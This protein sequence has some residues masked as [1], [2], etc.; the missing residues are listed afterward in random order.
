MYINLFSKLF[1]LVFFQCISAC[2]GESS[3]NKKE[4]DDAH[5]EVTKSLTVQGYIEA[6]NYSGVEVIFRVENEVF[7]AE[8]D[9]YGN[10][11]VELEVHELEVD[12]FVQAEANFPT[13]SG[14]KLVS[15]LGSFQ[16]LLEKSG[17][18]GILVR[19]ELLNVNITS[20]STALSAL[21]EVE[22]N[23][24]LMSDSQYEAA[25]QQVNP[26][27]VFDIA[28]YI[29]LLINNP[30]EARFGVPDEF[31]DVYELATNFSLMALYISQ[32]KENFLEEFESTKTSISKNQNLV[33]ASPSILSDIEDTYYLVGDN[34]RLTL[35]ADGT[36]EVI[37]AMDSAVITWSQS[38]EGLI[39]EGAD[40]VT[41]YYYNEYDLAF[42]ETHIRITKLNWVSNTASVDSVILNSVQYEHYPGGE[43]QGSQFIEQTL[44]S[45]AVRSSAE[46]AVSNAIE[47]GKTYSL[48]IASTVSDIVDPGEELSPVN[49]VMVLEMRFYGDYEN[50]G[51]VDIIVPEIYTDGSS[52]ETELAGI[53]FVNDHN[54]LRV[55][56][57]N[58]KSFAYTFLDYKSDDYNRVFVMD[59]S[60]EI[61]LTKL[62]S[63]FGQELDGWKGQEI[64]GM[65]YIP[66]PSWSF[67]TVLDHYWVELD[68]D[69]SVNTVRGLDLNLDGQFDNSEINLTP[70]L[71]RLDESGELT[72]RHYS[73]ES[74]DCIPGL[75]DP[76]TISGCQLAREYKWNLYRVDGENRF[77]MKKTLKHFS[78]MSSITG[79][80]PVE[81]AYIYNSKMEKISER[82]FEVPGI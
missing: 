57:T 48:P 78:D 6:G 26:Y 69:G 63:F 66:N 37:G 70:G 31:D 5:P 52:F 32:I 58:N 43:Y 28:A 72:I 55:E 14:V 65:Y 19:S 13:G 61:R 20:I 81:N 68:T 1:L 75:W 51:K 3:N 25:Y 7:N 27:T 47:L 50:G 76:G 21:L 73:Q 80:L 38:D 29:S 67:S 53:W 12:S 56:V 30:Q 40:L 74:E 44:M 45:F 22:N 4:T 23:G 60:Y 24:A 9:M 39:I 18:D 42:V 11:I 64:P 41:G 10:Y 46:L 2:S 59:E 16:D 54:Q 49:A 33:S 71:W 35:Q 34:L 36:G 77:Y 17:D 15:T 62:S 8:L 79:Q 82:P